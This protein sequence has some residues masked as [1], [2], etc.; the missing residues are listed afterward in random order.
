MKYQRTKR[1]NQITIS[2]IEFFIPVKPQPASRPRVGRFG[3]YY[4]K[5][6][7]QFRKDAYQF[8]KTLQDKFPPK[9]KVGFEIDCEIVCY[10]P[11]NPSNSY[12]RGDNDNY[13]KAIYDSITY[14]KLVWEDD[15]Q[16]VKNKSY[17]RYQKDGEDY[18]IKVTIR[19]LK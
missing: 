18:G 14:A 2:K 15:I 6:Y 17:K 7:T 13:E 5:G 19:E 10:R 1:K 3:A 11:K 8:L 9:A 12:P 16:I 4:S